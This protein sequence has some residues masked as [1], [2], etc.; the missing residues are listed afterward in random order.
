MRFVSMTMNITTQRIKFRHLIYFAEVARLG[1]VIKAAEALRISQPAVSKTLREL[2]EELGV[3]LFDRSHRNVVLTVSG[4]MFLQ[5]AHA[6]VAAL[7]Q[8]VDLVTQSLAAKALTITI[9]ALP[10]V[11]A[12]ILPNAVK[13]FNAAMPS[14]RIR[15]VTGPNEF[16]MSQLRRGAFDLVIGRMG[17]P[18]IMKG[19]SFE[20][21]YSEKVAFVV[22]CGHPLLSIKAFDASAIV[23]YPLL[24]P[25]E[26]SIIRPAVMR[27][28]FSQGLGPLR[29]QVE[30]VS[31]SFGRAFTRGSDAIWIISEGVVAEDVET[32]QLALLPFDT[33]QTLGPVGL[34]KRADERLPAAAEIFIRSIREAVRQNGPSA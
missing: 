11:S 9:G 13:L 25:P 23:D 15:I 18:D 28:L 16:L 20:H 34:T 2:E 3:D 19:F 4:S 21:L 33:S 29:D 5:Y 10:T 14:S 12:R 8:G 22:R 7:H 31:T 30:T 17:E 26:G 27:F 6:S 1:S 32:Q 24:M